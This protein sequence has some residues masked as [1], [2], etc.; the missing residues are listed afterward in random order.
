[1][2]PAQLKAAQAVHAY[3]HK[4]YGGI[5]DRKHKDMPGNSTACPGKYFPMATITGAK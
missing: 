1:M 3:L 2:P 4:K 5:P